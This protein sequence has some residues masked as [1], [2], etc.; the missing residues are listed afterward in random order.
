MQVSSVGCSATLTAAKHHVTRFDMPQRILVAVD[1]AGMANAGVGTLLRRAHE[2]AQARGAT[3]A[4][5]HVVPRSPESH[6]W[7]HESH[8]L[9][10]L[11][12]QQ[13]IHRAGDALRSAVLELRDDRIEIFLERGEPYAEVVRQAEVWR[14]DMVVVG[15]ENQAGP[16][17]GLLGGVAGRVVRFAHCPVLVSR[18]VAAER[19][20]FVATDLSDPS[21]P[22]IQAG[23]EEARV[24]GARLV[25]A[26]ALDDALT[27][28]LAVAG[29]PFGISV[30]VP[31]PEVRHAM[32]EAT[33]QLLRS[34]M[35]RY[36]VEGDAQVLEGGAVASIVGALESLQA[37]LL[38]VGTHGRTGLARVTLGSVAEQLVRL[39]PC[40]VL[41]VR[42]R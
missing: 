9:N 35:S 28:Y 5:V 22:A 15:S 7:F 30:P 1:S 27:E 40:S 39:S 31:T 29:A 24:R 26:H 37:E 42:Q 18:P 41:A 3:L 12:M 38:V 32:H 21:L 36:G 20:V 17:R 13:F 25:V 6:T 8:Q 2:Q 10:M 19:L 34:A 16:T 33:L 23:A 14:A 4:F 11:A